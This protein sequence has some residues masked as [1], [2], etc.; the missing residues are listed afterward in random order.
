[1]A[2]GRL[3]LDWPV[4]PSKGYYKGVDEGFKTVARALGGKLRRLPF[5]PRMSVH[6]LGGCPMAESAR[7]GVVDSHGQVFGHGGL[8][9]ADG[10]AM[11]GPVG[12]NPSFTIAAFADRV[13]DGIIAEAV[14]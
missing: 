14:P 8:Y 13:A 9:V 4:K 11:P 6:P 5:N 3:Q 7:H 2:D 1:M 12:A 10:A